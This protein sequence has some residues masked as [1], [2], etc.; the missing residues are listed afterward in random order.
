MHNFADLA[1]KDFSSTFQVSPDLHCVYK[2]CEPNVNVNKGAIFEL[3]KSASLI[4][5]S[6][7]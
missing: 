3:V 1:G 2:A 5:I 4:S 7:V 6:L